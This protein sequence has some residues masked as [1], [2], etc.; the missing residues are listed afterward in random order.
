[1]LLCYISCRM[2][3]TLLKSNIIQNAELYSAYNIM[4][5]IKRTSH[6]ELSSGTVGDQ[7]AH[8]IV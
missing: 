6:G 5:Y 3:Y 7:D 4:L 8:Q 2:K 1:M